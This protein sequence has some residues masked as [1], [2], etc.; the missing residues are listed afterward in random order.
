MKIA[1]IEDTRLNNV[2]NAVAA[3][4][5]VLAQDPSDADALAALDGLYARTERWTDLLSVFRRRLELTTDPVARENL[6]ASMATVYDEKLNDAD[7]AVRTYREILEAD[8]ASGRALEALDKLFARLSRWSDLAD[9]LQIRLD[10]ATDPN[11]QTDLML[12]LAQ[13]R[14]VQMGEIEAA[15][16]I[17]HQVLQ[18][19]ATSLAALSS[20]ERLIQQPTHAVMVAEILEPVY[21]E[22]G[23]YDKL[24][25]VNEIQVRFATDPARRVE[26]LH[27]IAELHESALDNPALA[28]Q[29]LARA[30]AEDPSHEPTVAALE[31]LARALGTFADLA[32]VYESLIAG[33]A[34]PELKLVLLQ[35]AATVHEEHL[36]DVQGAIAHYSTM[37]EIAPRHID[38]VSSLER[39]YQLAEQW[40]SLA[41]VYLKKAEL[42]ESPD[43]S[44]AYLFRATEIYETVLERPQDAVGVFRKI[45]QVDSE[46][47]NAIDALV[48]LFV[49]EGRWDEL[50]A[51]YEKKIDL[52][53]DP[54]EKK[55]LHMEVGSVYEGELKD[56]V[57]AI[58]AYNKVL[59]LDPDDLV[60]IQRLDHLYLSQQ[61]WREL[62]TILER[63]ADLAGDPNE[64]C[65]YR[66][67]IAE[68]Q[69]K[70]LNDTAKAVE[71]Y[72][73]ILD[74]LPEHDPSLKALD[75]ILHSE[76]D[77]L[78][79]AS[80]LEPVYTA[81]RSVRQARRCTRGSAPPHDRQ[82]S[83]SG[84]S[85][86]HCGNLRASAGQSPRRIRRIRARSSG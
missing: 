38:A 43:E 32:R 25:G 5:K 9:N 81:A 46:D 15:V 31:R 55:K 37:M 62:L 39:L 26:L 51:T 12:R 61:N 64:V 52:I 56:S 80:V 82:R 1:E 83:A 34:T 49:N 77:P 74:V 3:F 40:E 63:E 21:R 14:E 53:G 70:H 47:M 45:L 76:H 69:E 85:P 65:A 10:A 75:A 6:L 33:A 22:S 79:A 41:A 23:A 48:R 73:E 11:E 71:I 27:T 4:N 66:Y 86:S 2:E 8:P 50:L 54:D 13:L 78:T 59:E 24:V 72:R 35:R 44:K 18:R 19:D 17:Y 30:L 7:S 68:L 84:A 42:L 60:A 29:T 36:Q 57:R 67:R 28:F 16:E 20:L 58:D